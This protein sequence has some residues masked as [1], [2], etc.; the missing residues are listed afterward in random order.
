MDEDVSWFNNTLHDEA[1]KKTRTATFFLEKHSFCI[2]EII[3]IYAV[4]QIKS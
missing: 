4:L 2:R 3:Q 1:M